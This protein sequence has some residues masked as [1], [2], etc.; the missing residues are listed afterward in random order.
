MMTTTKTK[1]RYFVAVNSYRS[2]TS[3]GFANTWRVWECD[4]AAHQRRILRDGLPV[5][6]VQHLSRTGRRSPVFSTVGI[7]SATPTEIR[8]AK[9]H[10]TFDEIPRAPYGDHWEDVENAM[11][12]AM[13]A[14][15]KAYLGEDE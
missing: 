15:A 4:S 13:I 6:D 8:Q 2:S 1:R 10:E 3:S 5:S 11:A 12:D 14:Q 7:R 9:R